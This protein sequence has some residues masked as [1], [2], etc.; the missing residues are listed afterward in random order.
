M[1]EFIC[2]ILKVKLEGNDF[3]YFSLVEI[4]MSI[5]IK[6]RMDDTELHLK[7][8]HQFSFIFTQIYEQFIKVNWSPGPINV[9]VLLQLFFVVVT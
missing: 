1:V 2:S 9:V 7:A 3:V 5:T 8:S 6:E 4:D